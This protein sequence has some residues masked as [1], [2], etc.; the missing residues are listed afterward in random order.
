MLSCLVYLVQHIQYI[1]V[2]C[3]HP[4]TES[5]DCRHGC[6]SLHSKSDAQA[7]KSAESYNLRWHKDRQRQGNIFKELPS[8]LSKIKSYSWF[9]ILGDL[10]L[11]NQFPPFRS[12]VMAFVSKIARRGFATSPAVNMVIKEVHLWFS[13]NGVSICKMLISCKK[14]SPISSPL[15]LSCIRMCRWNFQFNT[16]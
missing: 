10:L 3:I 7:V 6:R 9:L 8:S 1:Q 2:V 4:K 14:F 15:L 11:S 12:S 13:D 16:P 5:A